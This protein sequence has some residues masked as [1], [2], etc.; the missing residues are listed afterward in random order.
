M[1]KQDETKMSDKDKMSKEPKE[2]TMTDDEEDDKKSSVL[3]G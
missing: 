3:S 1:T 2:E